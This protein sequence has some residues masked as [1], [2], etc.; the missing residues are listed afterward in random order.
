MKS[1]DAGKRLNN[2]K[3]ENTNTPT[4][5]QNNAMHRPEGK[6]DFSETTVLSQQ[7]CGSP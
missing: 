4:H 1:H 3:R 7:A 5:F 2:F 6:Q